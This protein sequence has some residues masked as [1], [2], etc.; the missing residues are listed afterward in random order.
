MAPI[1][2]RDCYTS[3]QV[4]KIFGHKNAAGQIVPISRATLHRWR[5]KGYLEHIRLNARHYLYTK[6]STHRFIERTNQ[7]LIRPPAET[8]A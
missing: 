5:E 1:L 4:R 2:P 6:A 7:T 8:S 3:Y